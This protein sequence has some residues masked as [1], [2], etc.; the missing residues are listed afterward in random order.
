MASILAELYYRLVVVS[1]D[2][3]HIHTHAKGPRFDRIHS[4]CNEYYEK[5]NEQSD[6]LVEMAIEYSQ[7][8]H[9]ASNAATMIGHRPTN[10]VSYGWN[11]SLN[12]IQ[13]SLQMLIEAFEMAIAHGLDSDVVSQLDE[14]LRYWKKE[15]NYKNRARMEDTEYDE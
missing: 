11:E 12:V 15:A 7:E 3:K 6:T 1:N 8:V 14:Y 10:Q 9:N 5:A 4:I 13:A 2:M